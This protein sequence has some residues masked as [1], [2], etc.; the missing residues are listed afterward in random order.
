MKRKS[1][2]LG[3]DIGTDSVGYAV[4]DAE[5]NILKFHG[6]PAWGVT[7]FDEASLSAERRGFRTS[8]RRLDR[9]QQRVSLIQELFAKAIA[10]VDPGFYTR[11]RASYIYREDPNEKFALFKDPGFTDREYYAQYPTIHHLIT[12]LMKN[13]GAH[14]VRL[15]YLAC[16]W[17]VAHRGHFLSNVSKE[18]LSE[19][20][21]FSSVYKR[22]EKY[23]S[24]N[25][26]IVPW[27]K[28]DPEHLGEIIQKKQGVVNKNKQLITAMMEGEKPSKEIK[29]E[30]PFSAE[31]IIKLI[32][33]GTVKLKDL[34]G[35]AEYDELG[36][37]SLGMDEDKF[38]EIMA[39]LGDDY[40]LIDILRGIYDW[41]VLADALGSEATISE[42]KVLIYKR[43][44][45]DL[46]CLKRIIRKYR[47]DKYDEIFRALD[48][49]NYTAYV[50]HTN[51]GDTSKLQ[52][53]NIELFSKYI[54]GIVKG[55]S[56]DKEDEDAYLDMIHRLELRTFMPKQKNTDNR[57]IPHQLY[58]YELKEILKNAEQYLPFLSETDGD[59]ISVSEKVESVF[60]FRIPYYVGPLN[61]SSS[62]A[63]LV[64]KEGKIYPWNFEEMVDLDE[65]E[66]KFIQRMTNF[67]TYLPGEPVLPKDSLCYH[68]FVVLNEINNLRIN[69]KRIS[70]EL[71]QR[72]YN[73]HFMVQ[74]KVTK[75]S[76]LKFLVANG[77]IAVGE[78]DLVTG[79]D[80]EIKSN[81]IPQIAFSRLI[82]NGVLTEADAEKIIER[83][84]YADD[85]SRLFRWIEHQYPYLSAA[86]VK[87][88]CGLKIKNFGRLSYRFLN[89]MEGVDPSTGEILSILGA[90]WNTT[91]NLNEL[92]FL[93]EFGFAK[94]I[95][96]F[97]TAYYAEHSPTL[98]DRMD[99]MYLSNSVRRSVYR[100][101]AVV[102]DVEKAFGKPEKIFVEMARGSRAE[103][104]GKRTKSRRQ[105]ILD[106]YAK[107]DEEDVRILQKQLEAMGESADNK[108]QSDKLFL[109]YMQLGRSMYSGKAI[110]L[111]KLGESKLYDIDHIFPQAVVKDDSILNNKVLVLS[112]ENGEKSDHYPIKASVRNKMKQYWKKLRGKELITDEK[113]RRLTRETPFSEDEKWGFINRQLTETSQSTKAVATLLKE[114]FPETELVYCK[115][116]LTSEFRQE[117]GLLKSRAFN[118]LHHA[119]DAYLNI[120]TG[121]VYNMR[122]SKQWFNIN[123][124]YSIK[125]KTLFTHPVICGNK[126]IWEGTDALKK[127]KANVVRNNA[128][129]TKY[130]FFKTGGL[131]DQ[132][133][134]PAAEGL[135]PIKKGMPTEIYGGYNKAGTMFYIPVR[136]RAGKK[137]EI[138]IMSVELLFGKRFL[139]DPEF[140]EMYAYKRLEHIL[141]KKIDD[142]AFPMGMRPWKINTRLS[143]DGFSV[144]ISGSASGGRCLIAQPIVQ[145]SASSKWNDYVKRL[146]KFYEKIKLNP[147]YQYSEKYDYISKEKNAELFKL[148]IDKAENSIYCKRINPVTLH[149]K[150]G[151]GKF[152]NLEIYQQAEVLL[153]AI[154]AFGRVSGGCDLSLIGGAKGSGATNGFSTNVSNWKKTYSDVRV[155]DSSVSG[156]WTKKSENILELI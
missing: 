99:E 58:W 47:P 133:P 14:D 6:E 141:K 98:S 23:F 136:Y 112:E 15:V 80:I 24:D 151:E 123:N 63:W 74:K 108:L 5:Y 135:T 147:K 45:K 89:E 38:G 12:E 81:L 120:V 95:E 101:L 29:D 102:K 64:R 142:I 88:I 144:C 149:L 50:Y 41:S 2:Y 113:Y 84:S 53:K 117:F 42:A 154:S 125:T 97:R 69:G 46:Q 33:G 130:A 86:D 93:P 78:E 114:K 83:A 22:F 16:A 94:A 129:F 119:K 25:G 59:G 122:F 153:N 115:A 67:C 76:L 37:V 36:S 18:N 111:E 92:L 77:V 107:C 62:H 139:R 124:S 82:K 61:K 150:K 48:K 121:N 7:I 110:E 13:K 118:D 146:E 44:E 109:Y 79:I 40:E 85:K 66:Q 26:F 145:F 104:K 3:L 10:E 138:I 11:I 155:I 60:L 75:K 8:R 103:Q 126:T 19:I 100:T 105:Q 72:I 152:L 73:E 17:L 143:L 148:L 106:L 140:A 52:K 96:E 87:Y 9:R 116:R 132:M 57:V 32:A 34:Y 27:S 28:I 4:T 70:I 35:K 156:L 39:N 137:S 21:N 56:V 90:L 31:A 128:H 71:K 55:I 91:Y 30:F 68:K 43:H 1:Y 51:D 131:F 20:R 134:V 65:S 127:V 49:D 54:L